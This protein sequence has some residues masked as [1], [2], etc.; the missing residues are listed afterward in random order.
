MGKAPAKK[1]KD[2]SGKGRKLKYISR[3][4]ALRKL[5]LPLSAFRKLC[6]LKGV[7]PYVVPGKQ[8]KKD[9][10]LR[11]ANTYYA[12]KDI[13][14]LEKEPLIEEIRKIKTM[15]K[16][17][18]KFEGRQDLKRASRARE[19]YAPDF[20]LDH[21]VRER[22]PTFNLALEDMDDALTM[23]GSFAYLHSCG[24]VISADIVNQCRKLLKEWELYLV[25]TRTLTKSYLTVKGIYYQAEVEGN[26]ITWVV[27]YQF[28]SEGYGDVDLKVM[29]TFNDLYIHLVK[30]V[31][32]KLYHDRNIQYPPHLIEDGQSLM[33]TQH[34][35][36]PQMRPVSNTQVKAPSKDLED[37]L[38]RKL[39]DMQRSSNANQLFGEDDEEDM[40]MEEAELSQDEADEEAE[41]AEIVDEDSA[42]EEDEDFGINSDGP[43]DD[44]MSDVSEEDE[45]NNADPSSSVAVPRINLSTK[46]HGK[47]DGEDTTDFFVQDSEPM[48]LAE[49]KRRKRR[50]LFEGY[51]VFVNRECPINALQ[52]VIIA[53]GGRVGWDSHTSPFEQSY[54]YITHEIVDR[55]K[56]KNRVHN[57]K[58]IQPQWVFDSLNAGIILPESRYQIGHELPPHLSPFVD[59]TQ[60]PHVP[61]YAK[62]IQALVA[63]TFSLVQPELDKPQRIEEEVNQAIEESQY[64]RELAAELEG[65]KFT[66]QQQVEVEHQKEQAIKALEKHRAEE[67]DEIKL[68]E[69]QLTGKERF[70]YNRAKR[71]ETKE[72]R[73]AKAIKKRASLLEAGL[74]PKDLVRHQKK[75]QKQK[76]KEKEEK[77]QQL[78]NS[79]MYKSK[80]QRKKDKERQ[81]KL[82]EAKEAKSGHKPA[83]RVSE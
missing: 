39:D 34:D 15:K 22:Y 60:E 64:A 76:Q 67:L 36:V 20:T 40:E 44:E 35:L 70:Y 54:E 55:P 3:N 61:D 79:K 81:K 50:T 43:S 58:Y 71:I 11:T 10:S 77:R 45:N 6:I 30:F 48:T 83:V 2:Y 1:G 65:K 69:T 38:Q 4:K 25:T 27:P 16:K 53:L 51:V 8:R 72:E 9:K 47:V 18:K 5:Q 21:I 80:A 28:T 24:N 7:F 41:N 13:L 57:R 62:E 73:R 26:T 32:F 59:W 19:I 37:D 78:V 68:R 63:Q 66:E 49:R 52:F 74:T 33:L 56:V 29:R 31:L 42:D 46:D 12:Y 14:F 17:V 23:L 75:M 82:K